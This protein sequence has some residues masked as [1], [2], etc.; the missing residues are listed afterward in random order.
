MFNVSNQYVFVHVCV[1]ICKFVHSI[2]ILYMHNAHKHVQ[3]PSY[4]WQPT[5]NIIYKYDW[6]PIPF[7]SL[8]LLLSISFTSSLQVFVAAF[9]EHIYKRHGRKRRRSQTDWRVHINFSMWF[10]NNAFTI[11]LLHLFNINLFSAFIQFL[12]KR[13]LK[14]YFLLFRGNISIFVQY[15]SKD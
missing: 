8:L 9:H 2:C 14:L 13:Q 12:W 11:Q 10:S 7:P 5:R 6:I 1:V 4:W 3:R 15:P